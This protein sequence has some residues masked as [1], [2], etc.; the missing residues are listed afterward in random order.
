[1]IYTIEFSKKTPNLP[2][3]GILNIYNYLSSLEKYKE[4]KDDKFDKELQSAGDLKPALIA[5][6]QLSNELCKQTMNIF[7]TH[8]GCEASTAAVKWI[9][10]GG[11]YLTGGITSKNIEYICSD[12]SVFLKAFL[13]KGRLTSLVKKIPLYAVLVEDLGERGAHWQAVRLLRAVH[14]TKVNQNSIIL[15]SPSLGYRYAY[16]LSSII[17]DSIFTVGVGVG[18]GIMIGIFFT[19]RK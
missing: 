7:L 13:D 15:S 3:L 16:E 14:R 6:N 8:Y 12:D 5:K 2:P 11:L 17:K 19:K 9:P 1:M 10:T 18:L 4:F